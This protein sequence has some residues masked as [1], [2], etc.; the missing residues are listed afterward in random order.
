MDDAEWWWKK[1]C[2]GDYKDHAAMRKVQKPS[3]ASKSFFKKIIK[4]YS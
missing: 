1:M 2:Y 4:N 3:E